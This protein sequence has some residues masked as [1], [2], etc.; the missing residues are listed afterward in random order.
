MY[1]I[2]H[3]LKNPNELN[4]EDIFD[5]MYNYQSDIQFI[6]FE[7]IEEFIVFIIN[8]RKLLTNASYFWRLL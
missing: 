6:Y 4:F 7:K 3:S 2:Y 1:S 5:G 8:R